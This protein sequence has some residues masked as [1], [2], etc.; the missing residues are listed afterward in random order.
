MEEVEAIVLWQVDGKDLVQNE[1]VTLFSSVVLFKVALDEF[2]QVQDL[3]LRELPSHF[4][5][6]TLIFY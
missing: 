2:L 3:E 4:Q 5:I 1:I 6:L